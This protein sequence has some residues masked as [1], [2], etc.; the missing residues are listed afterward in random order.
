LLPSLTRRPGHFTSPSDH[1][2][3]RQ[4]GNAH[5]DIS[6]HESLKR[7]TPLPTATPAFT[8]PAITPAI[9][10]LALIQRTHS[11]LRNACRHPRGILPTRRKYA[12]VPLALAPANPSYT[13]SLA[14]FTSHQHP[15]RIFYLPQRS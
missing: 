5:H 12:V 9:S 14:T 8:K 4:L 6:P 10:S 3:P 15:C 2:P 7:S 13:P 11:V 1:L